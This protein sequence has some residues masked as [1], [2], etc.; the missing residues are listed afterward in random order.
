MGKR[1]PVL[2]TIAAS[3]N[4]CC[5][6]LGQ[7]ARLV[8]ASSRRSVITTNEFSNAIRH[9]QQEFICIVVPLFIPTQILA[10][11]VACTKTD[12]AIGLKDYYDNLSLDQESEDR[13]SD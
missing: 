10:L 3:V 6:A 4:T 1:P 13:Q 12:T 9:T 11:P 8:T 7:S 2:P 5:Y